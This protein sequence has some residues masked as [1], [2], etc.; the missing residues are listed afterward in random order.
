MI[1]RW[2]S[3][4]WRS[5]ICCCS[6]LVCFC[7]AVPSCPHWFTLTTDSPTTRLLRLLISNP[8]C[9]FCGYSAYSSLVLPKW[10]VCFFSLHGSLDL[11]G[12]SCIYVS[13]SQYACFLVTEGSSITNRK[14][15]KAYVWQQ[16]TLS[17]RWSFILSYH[18]HCAMRSESIIGAI[19]LGRGWSKDA[20]KR[21]SQNI[22][23]LTKPTH[24]WAYPVS[25]YFSYCAHPT[26]RPLIL[27]R[28][29]Q[30]I[31]SRCPHYGVSELSNSMTWWRSHHFQTRKIDPTPANSEPLS[32]DPS[33]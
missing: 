20:H 4:M 15:Y 16:Q 5:R 7:C 11:V 9:I 10:W 12:F 1:K 24:G 22:E 31:S 28:L 33:G 13:C 2:C 19:L 25:A 26:R 21:W 32:L 23:R 17:L 14:A 18:L 3:T 29:I 30:A 6:D 8:K 27:I